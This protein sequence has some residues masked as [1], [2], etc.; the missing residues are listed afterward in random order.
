MYDEDFGKY[1]RQQSL[2]ANLHSEQNRHLSKVKYIP[3]SREEPTKEPQNRTTMKTYPTL[4][5]SMY[6]KTGKY[7]FKI[8]SALVLLIGVQNSSA[9]AQ[10]VAPDLV[11]K[12]PKLIAGVDNSIGAIYLFA[13][14]VPGVDCHAEIIDMV[15]GA[16]LTYIDDTTGGYYDAFQ[17]HV[18]A[19]GYDTSY[20]DWKFTFKKAG[21]STDTIF[22]CLAVTAIDVDG[23]NMDLKEFVEAA[24]PGSYGIDP[25][26]VLDI[27][28]DGVRNR[29]IGQITTIPLIDTNHRE[30]M[31]QMNFTNI[32]S[33]LYRNGAISTGDPMTRHTC[34]YF[35]PFITQYTVLPVKLHYFTAQANQENTILR[36]SASDEQQLNF[37][38]IQKSKDGRNWYDIRMQ[39]PISASGTNNYSFT[40]KEKLEGK[41]WYRLKQTDHKNLVTYSKTVLVAQKNMDNNI[42]FGQAVFTSDGL[43]T[44]V[45][46]PVTQ[47]I[48][49][50]LYSVSGQRISQQQKTAYAGTSNIQLSI[51]STVI[52]SGIYVVVAKNLDG[53]TIFTGKAIKK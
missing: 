18:W 44:M 13:D 26:S 36:W 24:T 37:Y 33:L 6:S 42:C 7:L 34:I 17:P 41:V 8:L 40:D 10:C 46:T 49:F 39:A 48:R 14:V 12:D 50:E 51:P 11:F 19:A 27:S 4:Q 43:Q 38:T 30:A 20:L 29:A 2:I 52:S 9:N 45:T 35:K 31:F 21:T 47:T 32:S 53:Q 28:F 23:N 5:E 25:F 22:P 3:L 16:G 1:L 15:N